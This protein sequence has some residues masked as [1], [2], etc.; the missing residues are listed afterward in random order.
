MLLSV[1]STGANT[2]LGQIESA[3]R[4][5]FFSNG[6]ISRIRIELDADAIRSLKE[7]PRKNVKATVSEGDTVYRV[8]AVHLKGETSFEPIDLKPSFTLNFDKFLSGQAFHGLD[9]IHLNNSTQD[10][11]LL[12]EY[13][14]SALFRAAGYPAA[15]VSHARV[16][17]NG[18][19]L[20]LYVL[21]EGY[22]KNFLRRH[23]A[24]PN[25]NFYD[26]ASN[27]DINSA[28]D[29]T[30]GDGPDDHSDLKMLK[31][32]VDERDRAKR[33]DKLQRLLWLPDANSASPSSPSFYTFMAVEILAGHWDGYSLH[34]NNYR[35]Y[36]DP[37]SG[38]FAFI[39]SG[40]DQL[41]VYPRSSLLPDCAGR[42]AA[43][44]LDTTEGRGLLRER[45]KELVDSVFR[46]DALFQ[47]LDEAAARVKPMVK[48]LGPKAE[49]KQEQALNRLQRRLDERLTF[50][51]TEIS[52]KLVTAQFN[53]NG[54]AQ[55]TGWVPHLDLGVGMLYKTNATSS[56]NVL[57]IIECRGREM[58]TIASW[59]ARISLPKGRYRLEGRVKTTQLRPLPNAPGG[60]VGIRVFG[61][62]APTLSAREDG[63][64]TFSTEFSSATDE[65]E[66]DIICETRAFLGVS[67]FDQDAVKVFRSGDYP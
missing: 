31:E 67:S 34:R 51:E 16:E 7:N 53:S 8:V 60:G 25:G 4:A 44:L 52:R 12:C 65:E 35:L 36:H 29:K 38:R 15:Q 11:S 30:S 46:H 49:T 43:T 9:K 3:D 5:A 33:L 13:L 28:L 22:N 24:D 54:I 55:V 42:V 2:S 1:L 40:M 6:T 14:G 41:F 62:P 66:R 20:G 27:Q 17:L 32:A 19:D 45:Q 39:P 63:W 18:R 50:L 58:P 37:H 64:Q 10:A 23:F 47:I 61:E 57:L 26:A 48:E 21:V 59:R 56:S